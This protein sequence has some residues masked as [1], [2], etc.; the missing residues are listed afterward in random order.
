M[1]KLKSPTDVAA[2]A[3]AIALGLLALG[4][5]RASAAF[6][7][8]AIPTN[9]TITDLRTDKRGLLESQADTFAQI[10]FEL[11]AAPSSKIQ[12]ELPTPLHTL[13]LSPASAVG[14]TIPIVYDPKNPTSA[15]YGKEHGKAGA[16]VLLALAIG[17]LFVPA[18]L[19]RS[20]LARL[21]SGGGGA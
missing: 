8:D 10:E 3:F 1:L 6:T 19:R 18:I 15:R 4:Q 21:A 5:L 13:G 14:S 7:A 17:A 12:T 20:T 2:A 16:F 9:A 11:I